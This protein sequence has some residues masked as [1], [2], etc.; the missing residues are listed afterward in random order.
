MRLSRF[1]VCGSSVSAF[2]ASGFCRRCILILGPCI[3]D[4]L[5][6][7]DDEFRARIALEKDVLRFRTQRTKRSM[8]KLLEEAQK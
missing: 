3:K 1:G 7:S 8:N 4:A 5:T 2:V 6:V